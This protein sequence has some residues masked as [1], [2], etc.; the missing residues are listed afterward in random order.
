MW[1][2]VVTSR[3]MADKCGREY[4]EDVGLQE[5]EGSLLRAGKRHLAGI[6]H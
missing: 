1:G 4:G 3:V 5:W 2:F 6:V